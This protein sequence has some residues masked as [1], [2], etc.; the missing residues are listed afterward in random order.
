MSNW[1][2]EHGT[3]EEYHL[4]YTY[5]ISVPKYYVFVDIYFPILYP[6]DIKNLY[7]LCYLKY[8]EDKITCLKSPIFLY[9]HT[10]CLLFIYDVM[11]YILRFAVFNLSFSEQVYTWLGDGLFYLYWFLEFTSRIPTRKHVAPT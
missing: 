8:I 6:N 4:E 10:L 5:N 7:Y 1:K 9:T 11:Y 2:K 3:H